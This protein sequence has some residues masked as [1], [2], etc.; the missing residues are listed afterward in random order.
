METNAPT[1]LVASP[2]VRFCEAVGAAA[3]QAGVQPVAQVASYLKLTTLLDA[4]KPDILVFDADPLGTGAGRVLASLHQHSGT[5]ILMATSAL[6][7]KR[8]S[9]GLLQGV[10]GF[11]TKSCDSCEYANAM[12]AIR[13]GEIWLGRERLALALASL[14]DTINLPAQSREITTVAEKLSPREEEIVRLISRGCTNKEVAKALG[15]SDKTVK[16]HLSHIFAKLGVNR[17]A[18]LTQPR[19]PAGAPLVN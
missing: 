14:I 8:V 9:D 13:R 4:V 10:C 19:N 15:M 1:A 6:S 5:A 17:R 12:R 7:D 16:A 18:Q 3:D 2:D 11:I